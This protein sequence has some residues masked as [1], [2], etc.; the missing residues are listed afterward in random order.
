MQWASVVNVYDE[1]TS[2]GMQVS[3][4]ICNNA[5]LMQWEAVPYGMVNCCALLEVPGNS[6]SSDMHEYGM[7]LMHG[8]SVTDRQHTCSQHRCPTRLH[9]GV[10]QPPK[11]RQPPKRWLSPCHT[12]STLAASPPT[13]H[14]PHVGR[15]SRQDGQSSAHTPQ[16]IQGSMT[17]EAARYALSGDP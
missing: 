4:A 6:R 17:V 9:C 1:L 13:H 15:Y 16:G 14:C 5:P 10:N 2:K 7:N 11:L 12:S 3:K 8:Q